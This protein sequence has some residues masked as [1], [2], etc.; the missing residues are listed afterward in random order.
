MCVQVVT[1]DAVHNGP[2]ALEELIPTLIWLPL[3]L[4]LKAKVPAAT[5][6]TSAV[7]SSGAVKSMGGMM[8]PCWPMEL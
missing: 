4:F 8:S 7:A 2:G 1:H 6:A 3:I 5:S